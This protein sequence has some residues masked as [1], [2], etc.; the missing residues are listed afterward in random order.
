MCKNVSGKDVWVGSIFF[1]VSYRMPALPKVKQN[2]K[3]TSTVSM[4]IF[5]NPHKNEI[6]VLEDAKFQYTASDELYKPVSVK[7][8]V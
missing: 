8:F 6:A 3:R 1:V 7:H 2:S 4:V 5:C